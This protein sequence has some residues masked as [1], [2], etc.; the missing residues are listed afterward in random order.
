MFFSN[1]VNNKVY[2]FQ[3]LPSERILPDDAVEA[4]H[5]GIK[6]RRYCLLETVRG[7]AQCEAVIRNANIITIVEQRLLPQNALLFM[8]FDTPKDRDDYV[9]KYLQGYLFKGYK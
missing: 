7:G 6:P 5:F 3:D 9:S 8:R 1:M 2:Y 4:A